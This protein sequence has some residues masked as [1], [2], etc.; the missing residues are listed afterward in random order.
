M[1]GI[2]IFLDC[3]NL[4]AADF[5]QEVIFIL[6]NFAVFH[7]GMRL[8]LNRDAIALSSDARSL[9]R[10][11]TVN[12]GRH[13]TD[14]LS[15]LLLGLGADRAKFPATHQVALSASA[16]ITAA[17]L[18]LLMFSKKFAAIF[19]FSSMLIELSS[20]VDN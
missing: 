1:G 15:E 12:F 11:R 4:A 8:G 13:A 20:R 14:Q 2:E 3:L 17:P 6:V 10:Q 18:P 16:F 7:L 19:L 5:Q 9:D